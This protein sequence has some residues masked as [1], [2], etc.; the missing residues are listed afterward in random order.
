MG[1]HLFRHQANLAASQIEEA[2]RVESRGT[3]F[4]SRENLAAFVVFG[5]VSYP[6]TDPIE[7]GIR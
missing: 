5:A 4:N 7:R 1:H 6:G 2:V 3:V